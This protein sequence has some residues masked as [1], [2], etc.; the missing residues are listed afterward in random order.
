MCALRDRMYNRQGLWSVHNTER[1]SGRFFHILGTYQLFPELHAAHCQDPLG[2]GWDCNKILP[3][4][5]TT[6]SGSYIL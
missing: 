4:H 3:E 2:E 5:S 1:P 6:R